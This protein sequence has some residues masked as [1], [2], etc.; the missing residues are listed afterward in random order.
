MA[1]TARTRDRIVVQLFSPA[2]ARLQRELRAF[3][4]YCILRLERELGTH[5]AWT[6]E[7]APSHGGYRTRVAVRDRG[8]TV[9]AQARGQDGPMAIWEAMCEVEQRLRERRMG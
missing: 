5:D 4:R 9:D 7:L 2:S 1:L 6:V 8:L 3:A